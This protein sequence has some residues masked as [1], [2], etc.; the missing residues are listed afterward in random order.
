MYWAGSTPATPGGMPGTSL[1]PWVVLTLIL[2]EL[3]TELLRPRLLL[4]DT[5]AVS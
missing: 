4:A 1:L 5:V 3:A 2:L